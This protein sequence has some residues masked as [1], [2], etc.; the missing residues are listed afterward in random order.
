MEKTHV[1]PIGA[2]LGIEPENQLCRDLK[3][4]WTT[5]FTLLGFKIT[6]T[7]GRVAIAKAILL[8]Q[9]V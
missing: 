1:I 9:F 8:S 2:E 6:N 4:H 7:S 3:L 5:S